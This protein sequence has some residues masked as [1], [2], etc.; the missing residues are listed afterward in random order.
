MSQLCFNG[1][2]GDPNQNA[3]GRPVTG[4]LKRRPQGRARMK[5]GKGQSKS[6]SCLGVCTRSLGMVL[7]GAVC[8]SQLVTVV[9]E[10]SSIFSLL[11]TLHSRLALSCPPSLP[12]SSFPS[13][14]SFP[15]RGLFFFRPT[16]FL[17]SFSEQALSRYRSIAAASSSSSFPPSTSSSRLASQSGGTIISSTRLDLV[18]Q[19]PSTLCRGSSFYPYRLP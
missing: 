7:Y 19:R 5:G 12:P 13:T 14:I 10:S 1:R 9:M 15:P 6:R 8:T 2:N 4:P 17:H 11:N 18:I 16:V 3:N